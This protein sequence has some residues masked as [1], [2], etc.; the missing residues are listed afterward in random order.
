MRK[1]TL[2]RVFSACALAA[3]VLCA[4]GQGLDPASILNPTKDS[5]PTY[6]GDYSGKRFSTLT[7]INRKN[8]GM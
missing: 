6:N 5:W 8:V 3:A 1:R 2:I 4:S 7:Q